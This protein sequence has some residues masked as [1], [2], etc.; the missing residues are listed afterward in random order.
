MVDREQLELGRQN[1]LLLKEAGLIDAFISFSTGSSVS[2]EDATALSKIMGY[3][4]DASGGLHHHHE[5]ALGHASL[6]IGFVEQLEAS[7][8]KIP[9]DDNT[10]I[11]LKT[12]SPPYYE[13]LSIEA[14]RM[15]EESI[16]EPFYEVLP[17]I[18]E[19]YCMSE[20]QIYYLLHCFVQSLD[21]G[22]ALHDFTQGASKNGLGFKFDERFLAAHSLDP[23]SINDRMLYFLAK[24]QKV[25]T[26]EF[27][28]LYEATR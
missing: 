8:F 17:V 23:E 2:K 10:G 1:F 9:F 16:T 28:T 22:L 5:T 11:V 26:S 14:E 27:T 18:G 7:A 21:V 24:A 3:R 19:C 12:L 6:W 4:M 13:L 15:I 25:T 20:E